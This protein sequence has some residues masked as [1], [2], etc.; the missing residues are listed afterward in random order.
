MHMQFPLLT[1]PS[2]SLTILCSGQFTVCQQAT[3]SVRPIPSVPAFLISSSI[4]NSL[5]PLLH[6]LNQP[7]GK[8]IGSHDRTHTSPTQA[9]TLRILK[10]VTDG[11]TDTINNSREMRPRSITES[12][13]YQLLVAGSPQIH[14]E[15]K[16]TVSL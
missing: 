9:A 6:T 1:L 7:S 16:N 11:R 3:C 12:Q 8:L 5:V 2:S 13:S 10:I 4:A 14:T 15:M